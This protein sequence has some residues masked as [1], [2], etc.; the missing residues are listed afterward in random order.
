LKKRRMRV[1]VTLILLFGVRLA[2]EP[3]L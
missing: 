1:S 3:L 2:V